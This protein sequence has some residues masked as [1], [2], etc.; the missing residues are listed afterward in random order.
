M[1]DQQ[2][3]LPARWAEL[4]SQS[5]SPMIKW[6]V[7]AIAVIASWVW[8]IEPLQIWTGDLH[9][10]VIRNADK[11]SR[12]LALEKNADQWI[13][14]QREAR[15]ALA[16][17]EQALFVSSSDT[18]SQASIQSMLRELAV[19][20]NL[21]LEF[22]K[23]LPAERLEPIGTRLAIEVALRGELIDVLYFM[24]DVVRSEKLFVIDQWII[25][26]E[27]NK[28]AYVRFQAAGIRPVELEVQQD[29]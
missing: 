11:A 25:Q 10:Q 23:L 13:D 14:A 15:L 28:K 16:E 12:L 20:R 24:D 18:Q 5:D 2:D 9:D 17:A 21:N 26:I 7:M 1:V 27:R 8:V 19:S 29:D 22:Q 3:F 4:K 6:G